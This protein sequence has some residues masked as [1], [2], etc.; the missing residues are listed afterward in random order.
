MKIPVSNR[1]KCCADCVERTEAVA[2]IGCDHAYT[3]MYLI[4]QKRAKRVLAM[5]INKG[6][7]AIAKKN[8]SVYGYEDKIETRLSDGM[9]KLTDNEVDTLLI[10]G[11]GGVLIC[12]I[13]E[14]GKR[15][16][17]DMKQMILQP[18][19]EVGEVRKFLHANGFRIEKE[20][21]LFEEGKYY[22]IIRAVPGVEKYET[23]WNY[24]YGLC[25]LQKKDRIFREFI[26]ARY[27]SKQKILKHLLSQTSGNIRTIEKIRELQEE[28]NVLKQLKGD[29]SCQKQ[30]L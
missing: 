29:L 23:E 25:L 26:I 12:H 4:E 28:L 10:G 6:P 3:S 16:L 2:D 27:E 14:N 30:R 5:D 17:P 7:L 20:V 8:I 15:F 1:M 9:E 22:V 21:M 11:M 13:L 18:Q 19:S 24:K